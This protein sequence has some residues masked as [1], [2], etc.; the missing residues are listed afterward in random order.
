[1]TEIEAENRAVEECI[2]VLK[3]DGTADPEAMKL[4]QQASQDILNARNVDDEHSY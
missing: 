3:E 2:N 1:M 4:C